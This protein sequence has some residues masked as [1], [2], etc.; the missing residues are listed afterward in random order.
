MTIDGEWIGSG[1]R[2]PVK[3]SEL[4][5]TGCDLAVECADVLPDGEFT[6]WIGAVGP[7]RGTA[8]RRDATHFTAQFAEPLDARIIKHFDLA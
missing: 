7:F 1:A 6:L 8:T 3:V 2:A 4:A 5:A